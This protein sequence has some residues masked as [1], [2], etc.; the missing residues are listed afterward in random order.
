MD[1]VA[2]LGGGGTEDIDE[3]FELRRFVTWGESIGGTS[4]FFSPPPFKE[5][6]FSRLASAD[7]VSL[8][9]SL[10]SGS[11]ILRGDEMVGSVSSLFLEPLPEER[12]LDHPVKF[13]DF[14]FDDED[15]D[16]RFTL[17]GDLI[18]ELLFG[19][20]AGLPTDSEAPVLEDRLLNVPPGESIL[21]DR[22]A[23]DLILVER[24]FSEATE[25]GVSSPGAGGMPELFTEE[26]FDER[27]LLRLLV[28]VRFL[29]LLLELRRS[30][31][32]GERKLVIF[33]ALTKMVPK[34]LK[35]SVS[36]KVVTSELDIFNE[37]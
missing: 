17:S 16:F 4:I 12:G 23:V 11:S 19:I 6:R 22:F 18:L 8:S 30:F 20:V 26:A 34:F 29:D 1:K 33:E 3:R 36:S 21:E 7:L 14:P 10:S 37:M 27:R 5:A 2:T 31:S 25:E 28:L 35:N 24:L 15:E 9:N 32:S 13:G